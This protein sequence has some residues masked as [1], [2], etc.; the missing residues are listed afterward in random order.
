MWPVAKHWE[1]VMEQ[2]WQHALRA[3]PPARSTMVNGR[4]KGPSS[5]CSAWG[6]RFGCRCLS[7]GLAC[8]CSAQ[9]LPCVFTHVHACAA[10]AGDGASTGTS[11]AGSHLYL[12]ERLLH[13]DGGHLAAHR[14]PVL[15]G[16]LRHALVVDGADDGAPVILPNDRPNGVCST[17]VSV[18]AGASSSGMWAQGGARGN[19][20][21]THTHKHA[22]VCML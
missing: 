16:V 14:C 12:F 9:N 5:A 15:L 4:A 6:L 8:H 21:N 11:M 1:V 17:T 3:N 22:Y 2:H 18:R 10:G 20:G 19:T 13:Q 7:G